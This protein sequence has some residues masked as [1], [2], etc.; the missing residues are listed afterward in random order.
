MLRLNRMPRASRPS[1][2]P[3][4][5]RTKTAMRLPSRL[6]TRMIVGIVADMWLISI[7]ISISTETQSCRETL[8]RNYI[9][10]VCTSF[11]PI[12]LSCFRS[13]FPTCTKKSSWV[14][15]MSTPISTIA[16]TGMLSLISEQCTTFPFTMFRPCCGYVGRSL[17]NQKCQYYESM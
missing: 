14:R 10:L 3:T 1:R 16:D 6:T 4:N 11:E 12:V 17:H 7:G 5:S 9:C 2:I 13:C 15:F 8:I